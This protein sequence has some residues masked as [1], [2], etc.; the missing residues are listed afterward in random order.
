MEVKAIK[1]YFHL[2]TQFK[3]QILKLEIEQVFHRQRAFNI[4]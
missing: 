3:I 4:N 1:S 2:E